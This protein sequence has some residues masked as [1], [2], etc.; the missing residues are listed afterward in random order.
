MI[1]PK[2]LWAWGGFDSEARRRTPDHADLAGAW[3][4]DMIQ[5]IV[6]GPI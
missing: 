3:I 5:D 2:S 1:T 6:Y 4:P